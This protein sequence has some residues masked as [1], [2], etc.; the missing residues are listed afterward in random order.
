MSVN[1]DKLTEKAQEAIVAAQ[2]LAEERHHTQLEPEHL[3]LALVDQEGGVVPAVLEKLGVQPRAL[4]RPIEAAVG[5]LA[6][7]ASPTRP[8]ASARL[9]RVFDNAEAEADRLKDDYVST[10]HFLLA[11]ADEHETGQAGQILR[12]AGVTRDKVYAGAPGGPRRPA[13]HQPDPRDDLPVAGEV[14]PRPDRPG[15]EGQA[16]PGHRPRRGDPPRHPGAQPPHQEQPGADRRAGRRQDGDRRGAGPA[17]RARRRAGGPQGQEG[18]RARPGR[19]G[20]RRQVPRRVR[21]AAQ[22]RPQGGHRQRGPDHPV[23]RRAAH[24]RR[25]RRGR[26]RDGRL[27]H[28]QA[29]AGPRRAALHRRDDARR[30]PQAHREGRR[31]RAPLPAGLR[32]RADRR[33]HD[34]ASCAA[35]AS[36]TSSTTRSASRTPRWSRPPCSPTATSPTASCRTRRSTWSTRPP[37]SCAWRRPACRPSWT[38]SGAGS[39]SWRSS[40]RG[41]ARSA[42]SASRERLSRLE[43]ELADLKEQASRAGGALAGGASRAE[44]RRPDPGDDST[45]PATRWSRRR[46]GPTGSAPPA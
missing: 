26:G 21:G 14:R 28:A 32:R 35:C 36:A 38:R 41:C 11:L 29:D 10:E 23:H 40:A 30:V 33:G 31:P 9:R 15:R 42:T 2:R 12:R 45:R 24:R 37:P 16:R 39:C 1:P 6:R 25:R 5:A 3:L 46:C 13:R 7:A 44:P 8:Y 43:K 34:L 22:G 17:H 20:R 18:R 4:L 19:A 27:Q